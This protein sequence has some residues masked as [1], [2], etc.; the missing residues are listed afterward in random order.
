MAACAEVEVDPDTGSIELVDYAA[1]ID[2]GTVV[3]TNLARV[4]AEGGL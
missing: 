4:Q 2:C 1:C 3:N